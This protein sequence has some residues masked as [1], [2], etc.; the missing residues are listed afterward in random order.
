MADALKNM[1]GGAKSAQAA[2]G[3]PDS[4]KHFSFPSLSSSLNCLLRA[5]ELELLLQRR[6][7]GDLKSK[8]TA[9]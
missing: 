5:L 1:F 8:E 6:N 7:D 3:K 9:N 4:G 2:A